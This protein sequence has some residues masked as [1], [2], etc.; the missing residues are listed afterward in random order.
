MREYR[1]MRRKQVA[2]TDRTG[3]TIW[4]GDVIRYYAG[5]K[6]DIEQ[7]YVAESFMAGPPQHPEGPNTFRAIGKDGYLE[8]GQYDLYELDQWSEV[9]GNRQATPIPERHCQL[10]GR[11]L[12]GDDTRCSTCGQYQGEA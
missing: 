5:S 11:F 4:V 8:Q 9:I 7:T 6:R 2:H 12:M 1:A 10:C 3:R